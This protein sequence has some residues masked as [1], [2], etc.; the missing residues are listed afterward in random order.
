M[1]KQRVAVVTGVTGQ[2]GAYLARH[3]LELGY[4]V[5]GAIRR[6]STPSLWRLEELGIAEHPHLE[7]VDFD[8]LDAGGFARLL[9]VAEPDEVYNLAAQ[10]F[11]GTSFDQPVATA[12]A[13]AMGGLH[14]LEAIRLVDP[15]IR[16]YQASS[17][18]MFGRVVEVPQRETTPFY[19]RSPYAVAKLFAHWATVNYR[20]SYG[21]FAVSGILFNHES[22]LRG[23]EFV[24]RKITLAAARIAHGMQ[25]VLELGNLDA[26]RDWGYAPEY[27][28]GMHRMLQADQP[29]D[30]VLATGQMTSVRKFVEHAFSAAGLPLS[31]EGAGP[32]ERGL[33]MQGR[34]RVRVN[35]RFYR[36]AEVDQLLGD[37]SLARQQL[38]WEATVGVDALCRRMVDADMQRVMQGK[39]KA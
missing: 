32:D 36:P 7:L 29:H 39:G 38:G 14:L 25:E 33:D 2:D 22:P 18:E 20:E 24:T 34:V 6:S 3:L 12:Q 21:M 30:Y 23:A 17:S 35:P 15:S 13:T 4:Q 8:L 1:S 11:V 37:A 10:S 31:W 16:Y 26:R 27:V 9:R 19:P 28:E 5:F